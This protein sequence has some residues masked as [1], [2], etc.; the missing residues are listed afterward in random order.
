[1]QG[2]YLVHHGIKGQKWGV[3]RFQ[4]EDGT[5]T[6][7]GK[8][9]YGSG[10]KA[11]RVQVS[12]ESGTYNNGIDHDE[13]TIKRKGS[14]KGRAEAEKEFNVSYD[15]D[16]IDG[17]YDNKYSNV[18]A[19][20]TKIYKQKGIDE[21]IKY[22]DSTLSEQEFEVALR[23]E[24]PLYKEGKQYADW[25]LEDYDGEP[26]YSFS[27]KIAGEAHDFYTYG[28]KDYTDGSRFIK[29]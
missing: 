20:A 29:K 14:A 24:G 10:E 13:V 28:D 27:L 11:S 8:L 4:N 12:R 17:N 2:T 6:E 15:G 25:I 18:G 23:R 5:W 16:Y 26:Y 22:I 21:A 7:E 19:E 9:R 3:R 1:M